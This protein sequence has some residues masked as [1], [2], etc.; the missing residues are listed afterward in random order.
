[1][2]G[3][4]LSSNSILTTFH[5]FLN[6]RRQNSVRPNEGMAEREGL[7]APSLGLT[8]RFARASLASAPLF[9]I[10]P[11]DFVEPEGS[12]LPPYSQLEK[13]S[14]RELFSNWRRG[15]DSNPRWRFKPPYSLSRGAPSASR[16]PLRYHYRSN[17]SLF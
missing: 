12:H 7:F 2:V 11:S 1:M 13:C 17:K 5:S 8:A 15:R 3:F 10:A 9:K 14:L 16:P 6:C 4:G